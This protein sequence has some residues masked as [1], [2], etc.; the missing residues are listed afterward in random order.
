MSDT[1]S[2]NTCCRMTPLTPPMPAAR[3]FA[4]STTTSTPM[5]R[6]SASVATHTESSRV[7]LDDEDDGVEEALSLIATTELMYD[8]LHAMSPVSWR[9]CRRRP[10]GNATG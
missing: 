9:P 8:R 7:D 6:R 2:V 5:T 4:G 10:D 1:S 3:I